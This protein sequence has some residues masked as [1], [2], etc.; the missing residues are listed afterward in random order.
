MSQHNFCPRCGSS[1]STKFD[2]GRDRVACATDGCG[3]M[4]FGDVSIGCGGVVVRDGKILLVQRG[5]NPGKGNWQIPGGYVEMD[6]EIHTAVEREVLEEAGVTA[7]VTDSLGFRHTA[8]NQ[9]RPFSNL[10]V[11]FRLDPMAGEPRSDGDETLDAGYFTLDEMIVKTGIQSLSL[12]A[13][14]QALLHP[15]LAGFTHRPD[16]FQMRPGW[17]LFGL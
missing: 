5:I 3:Y 9:E 8:G 12:W 6:E 1:L 10:Y 16:D 11:V 17:S 14:K 2:G 15:P 7:R 13:V 4:H